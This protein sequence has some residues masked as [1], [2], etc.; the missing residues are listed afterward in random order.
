MG[1]DGEY[2]VRRDIDLGARKLKRGSRITLA[3]LERLA[4]G[5]AG[6]L[7]RTGI[8]RLVGETDRERLLLKRDDRKEHL[9]R[10]AQ[11]DN[12]RLAQFRERSP[13]EQE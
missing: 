2:E 8:V 11:A 13:N 10:A 5:K 3:E 6:P 7:R 1:K 4:P 12:A 9:H